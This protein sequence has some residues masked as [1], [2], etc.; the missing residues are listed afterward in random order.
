MKEQKNVAEKPGRK[1]VIL[2]A[3]P[4]QRTSKSVMQETHPGSNAI[5]N[6]MTDQA[7]ARSKKA[8][9]GV[10]DELKRMD[11]MNKSL[12]ASL[13]TASTNL[14]ALKNM[15]NNVT[16][17]IENRPMQSFAMKMAQDDT[18]RFM[19][20][21]LKKRKPIFK[22]YIKN[23]ASILRNEIQCQRKDAYTEHDRS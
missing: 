3:K 18:N 20:L 4:A 15:S 13:S 10:F 14:K 21:N 2:P 17:L 16:D 6:K 22:N 1:L 19:T 7:R 9:T 12:Y 23:N 8:E 5:E 11:N